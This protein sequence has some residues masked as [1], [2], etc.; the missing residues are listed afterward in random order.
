MDQN[1]I[2]KLNTDKY[3]AVAFAVD[4]NPFGFIDALKAA[5]FGAEFTGSP[6]A[7]KLTAKKIIF[8]LIGARNQQ[9]LTEV[10]GNVNYLNNDVNSADYTKG[11]REYFI[12]NT[13]TGAVDLG[14]YAARS[15]FS[16]DG[17]FAGL[18]AGLLTYATVSGGG[19]SPTQTEQE[20][21]DAE[22]SAKKK[23]TWIIVGGI[24]AVIVIG[25]I[26]YL[27]WPSGTKPASA[28]AA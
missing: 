8:D 4:N 19:G 22:A 25:V 17:L 2:H 21:L 15:G 1:T 7:N 3:F 13:P 12:S 6:D 24:I 23:K 5:G 27:L 18:G 11:Y 14:N 20:R 26:T 16:F 28:K 9:K 10:F